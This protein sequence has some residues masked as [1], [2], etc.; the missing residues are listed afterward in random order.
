M[1]CRGVCTGLHQELSHTNKRAFGH[2]KNNNIMAQA[3]GNGN[4][5]EQRQALANLNRLFGEVVSQLETVRPVETEIFASQV[6]SLR[7]QLHERSR[8]M[9]DRFHQQ[10]SELNSVTE[11]V[12]EVFP[13]ESAILEGSLRGGGWLRMGTAKKKKKKP[14][15]HPKVYLLFLHSRTSWCSLCRCKSL[16][17]GL[18]VV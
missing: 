8:D 13:C 14:A 11:E 7:T 6:E 16:S 17:T 2:K 9:D 15:F 1:C 12:R 10:Q 4:L 3:N 18:L 5:S